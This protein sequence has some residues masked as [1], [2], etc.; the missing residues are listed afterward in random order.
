MTWAK[1]LADIDGGANSA[2][3]AQVALRLGEAFSARVELLHIE[4]SDEE[5]IPI[6]AEGMTAGAVGRMLEGL[7]E[8]RETKAATAQALYQS[9]CVDAGL[10]TCEPDAAAEPGRFRVAFRRVAGSESDELAQRGRLSDLVVV[11]GPGSDAGF[12]QAVET[13]IFWTGRPLLMVPET[14]PESSGRSIAI[15]WDGT[16]GAARAAGAALPLL[17]RAE[18]VTVITADMEKVGAKPSALAGYLA[19][20]GVSAQTWA[21]L[22]EDRALGEQ[23]LAEADK[24]G[25]DTLVMGAYGH[26]RL[27]EMV[28]GGVTQSVTAKAGIPVFMAH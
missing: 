19:E 4:V 25:A 11:G 12:S 6:V 20:H 2:T 27:L 24:A 15:A 7:A 23:L 14:L 26:N 18:A 16:P 5:A 8:E 13:A 22:S 1:L 9:L 28:L 17:R 10:P 21:F 3:V